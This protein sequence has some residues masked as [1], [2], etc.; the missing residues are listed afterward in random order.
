MT[1]RRRFL[2][3]AAAAS[4]V[5]WLLP[6]VSTAEDLPADVQRDLRESKEIL[7]ATRRKTGTRSTIAP[8]WFWYDGGDELFFTTSPKSWKARRLKRGSPLYVWVGSERGPFLV[9]TAEP[10]TDAATVARMGEA[11]AR[12]YWIAWVGFFRPRPERVADG[13]TVAYR[14]KLAPGTPPPPPA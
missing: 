9:G 8:I 7:V 11:Y 12:K 13:R 1:T 2:H 6:R 5:A 3:V 4:A 10:V 14:V